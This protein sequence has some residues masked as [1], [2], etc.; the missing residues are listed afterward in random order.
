MGNRKLSYP[1][2]V[3]TLVAVIAVILSFDYL[4]R[5][6]S[7]TSDSNNS[8]PFSDSYSIIETTSFNSD[9][10]NS[11]YTSEV[12][13]DMSMYV[14]IEKSYDD[15]AKGELAL[16]SK[17]HKSSFP[18]I[19]NELI[20][21]PYRNEK[22]YR[23][24][25]YFELKLYETAVE[26]IENMLGD[27][28]SETQCH[29][30]TITSGYRDEE[31]QL[32]QLETGYSKDE[33]GSSEHHTGYAF[34]FKLVTDDMKISVL[35]NTG[36]YS[37]IYDNSYKYGIVQRYTEDKAYVTDMLAR[38]YHFRYVGVPHAYYMHENNLCLEEYIDLLKDYS[39]DKKH[40]EINNGRSLYEVY[41]IKAQEGT[42]SVYVPKNSEYSVS[43]N[44][45]DGFI[46]T[47]LKGNVSAEETQTDVSSDDEN[48]SSETVVSDVSETDV[49]VT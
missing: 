22:T 34:D 17:S 30:V 33:V 6:F 26:A 13:I 20:T 7:S 43:G 40:L 42:T 11:D 10:E 8:E 18:D 24:T 28:Y 23:V 37:W 15:I 14:P 1:R 48:I 44:N 46:V 21:F 36:I 49:S 19:E 27:F 41:Y 3:I 25:D 16:V 5:N 39:F 35:E 47:V 45:V 31:K 12:H 32:E 2:I 9:N 29:D 38:S 4:R